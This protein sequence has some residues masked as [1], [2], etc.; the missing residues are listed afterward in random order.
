[1]HRESFR[2]RR[3]R[4]S[5]CDFHHDHG[6]DWDGAE[7]I[8]GHRPSG[9]TSSLK[10]RPI[11]GRGTIFFFSPLQWLRPSGQL[12]VI[13]NSSL[14]CLLGLDRVGFQ[15]LGNGH[16]GRAGIKSFNVPADFL[17]VCRTCATAQQIPVTTVCLPPQGRTSV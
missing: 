3:Q 1:M 17:L 8:A 15:E 4:D 6:R 12:C 16:H 2:R 11:E 14:T 9:E 10:R 13:G 5:T 7:L